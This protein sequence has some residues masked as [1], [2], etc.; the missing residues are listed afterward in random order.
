VAF[1]GAFFLNIVVVL[2]EYVYSVVLQVD[3]GCLFINISLKDK[4]KLWKNV[5]TANMHHHHI[6][7]QRQLANVNQS[8]NCASILIGVCVIQILPLSKLLL[9]MGD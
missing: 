7:Q 3:R 5:I 2:S 8:I 1:S 4:S 6:Q 9:P